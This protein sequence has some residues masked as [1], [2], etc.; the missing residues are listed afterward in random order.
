M[1][2]IDVSP[3]HLDHPVHARLTVR[4]ILTYRMS[5]PA[6]SK[7]NENLTPVHPP[8]DKPRGDDE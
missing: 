1:N 4:F 7:R 5:K 2:R 6:P 3:I 8:Q